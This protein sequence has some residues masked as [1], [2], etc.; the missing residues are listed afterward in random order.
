MWPTTS[1]IRLSSAAATMWPNAARLSAE[2]FRRSATARLVY[3]TFIR[4]GMKRK[5]LRH[6][7]RLQYRWLQPRPNSEALRESRDI[8]PDDVA[9]SLQGFRQAPPALTQARFQRAPRALSASHSWRDVST[10]RDCVIAP[11]PQ[12][13]RHVAGHARGLADEERFQHGHA[14][15][16]PQP[17][18]AHEPQHVGFVREQAVQPVGRDA[19]DGRIETAPALFAPQRIRAANIKAEP[20]RIDDRL[21]Q[22]RNIAQSH[23][24]ALARN[25]MDHMRGVADQRDALGNK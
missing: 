7:V 25:W 11:L 1:L 15:D 20:R 6:P 2:A 19:H 3:S 13:L 5:L 4:G 21:S 22:R 24:E 8:R 16:E 14:V 12:Q 18:I 9:R 10:R 17:D 23:V